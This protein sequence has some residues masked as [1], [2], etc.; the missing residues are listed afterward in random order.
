MKTLSTILNKEFD[1]QTFHAGLHVDDNLWQHDK[2]SIIINGESFDYRTGIG[3]RKPI[4]NFSRVKQEFNRIMNANPKQEKVNLITYN[5]KLSAVSKPVAP[6]IDD[7]LYSLITD[8]DLS[9]E[10]FQ[11]FCDNLGYDT[12][13]IKALNI[14]NSCVENGKKLKKF[15][16][17][18]YAAC[19]LFQ[20]Y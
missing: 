18:F 6:K 4:N 16:P 8:A 10:S 20:D 12:D 3:H 14:Y 2:W 13:S 1:F 9:I 5:R 19:E 17:D 11:D 15:I 7:V